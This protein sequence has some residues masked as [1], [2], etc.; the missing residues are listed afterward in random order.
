MST[1]SIGPWATEANLT[2]GQVFALAESVAKQLG[3]K[4]GDDIHALVT[5]MGGRVISKDTLFEDPEKSGSLYVH[6]PEKFEIIVPTHTSAR[7]DRFTIAHE[8]GHYVV[9]YLYKKNI[10][11]LSSETMVA[12]RKGSDRVEWEANWFAAGFLMPESEFVSAC[13]S[14]HNSTKF[15]ADHFD[16]SYSAAEVR[17]KQ[18]GISLN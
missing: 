4:P 7:R 15:I 10:G 1:A 17:A 13:Q 6:S 12:L 5:R 14:Y 16:V 2:K 9:H 3:F 11:T 18:L 8:L